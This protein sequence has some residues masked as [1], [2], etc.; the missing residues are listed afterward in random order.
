MSEQ[1]GLS[2][3]YRDSSPWP[4]FVALGIVLTEFGVFFGGMFIPVGVGGIILLEGTVVGILREAGYT[5][6]LWKTALGVGALFTAAGIGM[7]AFSTQSSEF[8]L[9]TRGV[10]VAAGGAVALLSSGGLY[11]WEFNDAERFQ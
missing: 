5:V 3:Q 1:P 4:L 6:T 2:D 7:L 8:N 9:Y 10:A 11:A